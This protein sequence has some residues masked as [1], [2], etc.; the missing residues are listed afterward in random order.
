M[1]ELQSILSLWEEIRKLWL[2]YNGGTWED[3]AFS[4]SYG[5]AELQPKRQQKYWCLGMGLG[6]I[7]KGDDK[8]HCHDTW[9]RLKRH[10]SMRTITSVAAD[11]DVDTRCVHTLTVGYSSDISVLP[12]VPSQSGLG[13]I[14]RQ[15]LLEDSLTEWP[16]HWGVLFRVLL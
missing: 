8:C 4:L 1:E 11:V 7:F 12:S 10:E 13:N 14:E 2:V 15:A 3:I 16:W 9:C 6:P 5:H